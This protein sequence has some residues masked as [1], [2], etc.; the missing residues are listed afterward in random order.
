MSN[1]KIND[2]VATREA[3][4]DALVEVGKKLSSLLVLDGETSNSTYTDKFQKLFPERFLEMFIA[5]QNI[6]S[7]GLG[8]SKMGFIPVMATFAAFWTR[9][10]DQIRMAQYSKPDL[11]FVG[12]HAGVAIGADGP[13]QMGLEDIAMFRSILNSVVLYPSDAV[14]AAK[15][16]RIMVKEPGLFYLRVTRN[17]TPVIYKNQEEFKIGSSKIH[18]SKILNHKSKVLIMAAGITVHEALKAQKQLAEENIETVV[19]DCYSVK[20]LDV[21]TIKYLIKT[22]KNVVVVEDHYPAGGLG[23]AILSSIIHDLSLINFIHLYVRKI[24][25]S[26]TP[27]ELLAYEEIDATAIVTTVKTLL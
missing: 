21:T 17:K 7:V 1:Y 14:S 5:E 13:S 15:L 11:K 22:I 24:P 20:P 9:A 19:M 4:G 10:F 18:K 12:S 26:G 23:E 8:L 3:F 2:L 27:E 16:T 6:A 25:R